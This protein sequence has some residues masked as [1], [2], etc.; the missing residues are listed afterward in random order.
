ML[1]VYADSETVGQCDRLQRQGWIPIHYY[2]DRFQ[3][4]LMIDAD[5]IIQCPF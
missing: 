2:G 3:L 5:D 4:M 1:I